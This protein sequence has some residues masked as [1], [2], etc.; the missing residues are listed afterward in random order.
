MKAVRIL[1]HGGPEV[2]QIVDMDI[3]VIRSDQVLLRMSASALNHLDLW[4]RKGLPGV[5][6]PITL[7]SDGSGI[8]EKFGKQVSEDYKFQIGDE[9]VIIPINSCGKCEYCRNDQEN[10]CRQF[11]I[12]GEHFDGFQSEYVAIRPEYLFKKPPE[13]TMIEAASY[14]L[15]SV[16][17]YHM[18]I[19]KAQLKKDE[20]VLVY[21]ASSGVGSMA[22]QIARAVG[23][24]VITTAG[25]DHKSKFA[26]K[27]GAE[28]VI[29]YKKES[30]AGTVKKLTDENGVDVVFEHTGAAT[31]T[32]SIRS[33]KRGGRLVICGATTGPLVK[34]DLRSLFIKNQ[35]IIGSTMGTLQDMHKVNRLIMDGKL[36]PVVDKVFSYKDIR[37]AH[38]H[39]ESGDQFGK[40][41][42]SFES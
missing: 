42:I 30:I 31:W 34:I 14:P 28:H 35:Q 21:G 22:V 40:V 5:P 2:L 26:K 4:V 41:I 10:L 17:A 25:S 29:N 19:R 18:L 24:R 33:L 11:R 13:V 37:A 39:L 15:T 7:G 16:T 38:Q 1:Q 8:I 36:K 6:L 9:V 12:P 32:D 20:W 23:A 3:P 27:L